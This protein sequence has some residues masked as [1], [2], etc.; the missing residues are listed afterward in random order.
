VSSPTI[1]RATPR[2][3]IFRPGEM[4][5]NIEKRLGETF[6]REVE[7]PDFMR[8]EEPLIS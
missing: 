8:E 1:A 5:P 2:I 4:L 7:R 3:S 6:S